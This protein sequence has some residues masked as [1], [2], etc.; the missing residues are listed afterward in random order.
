MHA[1]S[2]GRLWVGGYSTNDRLR[3]KPFNGA[4]VG[5]SR[6]I[7]PQ[8]AAAELDVNEFDAVVDVINPENGALLATAKFSG[9][10]LPG[11]S[12]GTLYTQKDDADGNRRIHMWRLSIAR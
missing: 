9:E 3:A 12:D 7:R 6:V 5:S 2:E 8:A 11:L 4:M 1:D 10:L